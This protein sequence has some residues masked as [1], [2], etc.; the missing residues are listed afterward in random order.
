MPQAKNPEQTPKPK[1]RNP[2]VSKEA[3]QI[4]LIN[5]IEEQPKCHVHNEVGGWEVESIRENVCVKDEPLT[6]FEGKYYCLFHL[7]ITDKNIEKFEET[8]RARL[9]AVEVKLSTAE[10]TFEEAKEHNKL[11]IFYDFRYLWI[12][13]KL[14]LR[15]YN[16]LAHTNF[17]NVTFADDV[18][19]SLSRFASSVDFYSTTF[20]GDSEFGSAVFFDDAIF[21]LATFNKSASFGSTFKGSASFLSAKFT[22]D[23][24]FSWAKFYADAVFSE[25]I[26]ADYTTFKGTK[27]S[28]HGETYF[29]EANFAK[30]TF[31]D[32][33]RFRNNVSFQSAIFGKDSDV[34]FRKALF[35]K[36]VDF[37]YCTAEGYLRFSNLRQGK[38]CKFD[39]QEAA[40]E[41]ATR[42]SFH[43]ARLCPNWF[44]NID[45]RK[46]I[47]TDIRWQNLRS[48]WKNRK[49][50]AELDNLEARKIKEQNKRLLE[51]AARQLAVNAEENNR[52]EEA[53]KFRYMAMEIKRLELFNKSSFSRYL[54]WLYKWT[55]SYGES[56]SWAAF[57]LVFILFFFGVFYNS[58]FANFELPEKKQP[59]AVIEKSNEE[60]PSE[61]YK[62]NNL[63]GFVHS[64]YVA[65]LQRPEPKAADTTTRLFIILETIFAP[66]QAALLALAIRRKFMR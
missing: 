8:F 25:T 19:F 26:F 3:K 15:F 42:I 54:I 56:W 12:P 60:K 53:A 65:A 7:P 35:A 20:I 27:F 46:F 51:I 64:L 38:D 4:V 30:N 18:D 6:K 61:F 5:P 66:L 13:S 47:F 45:A 43:T 9:K 50:R 57:V 44:V 37:Q 39:F 1:G 29:D 22:S 52:Y 48:G 55:S 34:F 14:D 62:M 32:R 31:F 24:Y 41:K 10:K 2:R 11:E 21:N 23:A 36:N 40:F 28:N 33:T 49:I 63:E 16:F 17:R 59:N 58:P